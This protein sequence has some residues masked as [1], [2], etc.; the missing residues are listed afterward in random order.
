MCVKSRPASRRILLVG[1]KLFELLKFLCPICL[2][3][4]KRICK[5]APTDILGK[6]NLL[7]FGCISA[8]GFKLF[9]KSDRLDIR[10]VSLFLA[11]RQVEAITYNEVTALRLFGRLLRNLLANFFVKR[12]CRFVTVICVGRRIGYDI[13]SS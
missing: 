4:V 3:L 12:F 8:L 7:R 1:K 11:A 6:N 13:I 2:S 5:T 9:Y 10:L